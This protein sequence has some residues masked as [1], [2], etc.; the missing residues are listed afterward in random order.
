MAVAMEPFPAPTQATLRPWAGG[1]RESFFNAIARH[2][3][4]AWRVTLA[5][6]LANAAV[7]VV[8]AVLMSPLFYALLA[9]ILDVANLAVATP[10]LV[11]IIGSVIGPWFDAPERVPLGDW[12]LAGA[13]AAIPG[14]LWMAGVHVVLARALRLSSL[15]GDKELAARQPDA[16]A[17]AEQRFANVVSEMA[18]AASI[19]E[20]RVL[21]SGHP[22]ANAMVFG[23]DE[24]HATILVSRGLLSALNREQ[25]QGVAANLI[26][27]IAN[28]DMSIGARVATTLVTLGL[29]SR[30]SVAFSDARAGARLL[31]G[32]SLAVF[33]PNAAVARD[34]LQQLA[35]PF[36]NTSSTETPDR[37]ENDWRT[38][39]WIPLAGPLFITGIFG[40]LISL[41]LLH[42]LV[43]LAWRQRKYM[44]DATAVRLTR[45][46]D[47][48]A[49]ALEN[50]SRLPSGALLQSWAA[51][52]S[53]VRPAHA[54]AG[55]LPGSVVP[56]FPSLT[57]RLRAL[58]TMGAHVTPQRSTLPTRFV[59]IV[60]PLGALATALAAF[61]M[62]LMFFLSVALSMLFLGLPFSLV[63]LLLRWLG[64]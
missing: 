47:A 35:D 36:A 6:A 60:V 42:P 21:I 58:A 28:G 19:P 12:L 7:A 44:A 40:G 17:L 9:L 37:K 54:N 4:A 13:L 2:R 41:F 29:V 31:G 27:S 23:R 33:R 3:R 32:L 55:L 63:H 59:L 39:L 52:L 50:M 14:L 61:A 26:G 64:H 25:M 16:T 43:A 45:D 8:I 62:Y 5:S 18:L 53:V 57:R 22:T 38:L 15:F 11:S 10:N 49:G 1:E 51:H 20:P 30:F 48:L 56:P 46:P 24:Q 34:L